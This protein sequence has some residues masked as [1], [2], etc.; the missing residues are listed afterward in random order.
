MITPDPSLTPMGRRRDAVKEDLDRQTSYLTL[1]PHCLL[2]TSR[3][4]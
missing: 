4:V 1:L 3:C 2:Y